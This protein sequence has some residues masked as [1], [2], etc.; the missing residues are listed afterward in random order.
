MHGRAPPAPPPEEPSLA[1]AK[2]ACSLANGSAHAARGLI[3]ACVAVTLRVALLPVDA[4]GVLPARLLR[5]AQLALLVAG[6]LL[7]LVA[8]QLGPLVGAALPAP[9]VWWL[10]LPAL[11]ALHPLLEQGVGL[12]LGVPPAVPLL[13]EAAQLPRLLGG[14]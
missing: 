2:D 8:A 9:L 3:S 11:L 4:D 13:L 14:P 7:R 1:L 6:V 5:T 12:L 10:L